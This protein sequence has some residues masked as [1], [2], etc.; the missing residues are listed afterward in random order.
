MSVQTTQPG[1]KPGRSDVGS[2]SCPRESTVPTEAKQVQTD[3]DFI[4]VLADALRQAR[5]TNSPRLAESLRAAIEKLIRGI[6]VNSGSAG[7]H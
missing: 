5:R 4:V 2:L 6:A 7:A 1:I 3:R